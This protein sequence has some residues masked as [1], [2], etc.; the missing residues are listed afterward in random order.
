[1]NEPGAGR[2]NDVGSSFGGMVTEST[3][4][5]AVGHA[6]RECKEGT[7][8]QC[9]IHLASGSVGSAGVAIGGRLAN[10]LVLGPPLV[11]VFHPPEYSLLQAVILLLPRHV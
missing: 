4:R 3:T 10:G 9:G 5:P 1:M 2:E 8:F 7:N 11:Y 6:R